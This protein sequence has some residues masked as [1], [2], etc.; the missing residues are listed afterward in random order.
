MFSDF[1]F[2]NIGAPQQGQYVPPSD[3]GRRDG[4][5]PL[6]TDPFNRDGDF[7]DDKT[8][9]HLIAFE[10]PLTDDQKTELDGQFKTPSLRNVSKTA[11]YMHD[12]V[13]DNLWDVVNHYNFG[14]ETGNYTGEKDPAISP[15]LLSNDELDDL[16]EFLQALE[17]GPALASADFPE[18]LTAP[19]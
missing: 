1:G 4:V 2:H 19:P 9:A 3:D 5:S 6:A 7:S 8:D 17:D 14:G 10:T 11:P 18:G 15:L 16:V 12:G 13:Y